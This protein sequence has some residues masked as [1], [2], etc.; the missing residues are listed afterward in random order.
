MDIQAFQLTLSFQ[1]IDQLEDYISDFREWQQWKLR[2][3]IKKENDGRGAH[4][5]I[6]HLKCK[7]MKEKYPDKS[8]R[9]CM[10]IINENIK[11]E[12]IISNDI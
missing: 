11:E 6:L 8:Y 12:N 4:V 5:K 10:K 7:E 9:E 1:T 3:M 2:K